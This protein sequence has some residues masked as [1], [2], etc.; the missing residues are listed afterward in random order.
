MKE[1]FGEAFASKNTGK[2]FAN[3]I[4]NEVAS[5][6]AASGIPLDG[7]PLTWWK[8]NECKYPHIV[9][10]ARCCLALQFLARGC[11]PRQGT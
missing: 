1:L 6:K 9:M 8:I 2:T 10:M 11:S 5:Y 7:D 4:K 3:T